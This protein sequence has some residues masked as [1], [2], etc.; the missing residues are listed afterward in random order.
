MLASIAKFVL[1]HK[2]LAKLN[3]TQRVLESLKPPAQGRVEY[4]DAFLTGFV[5]RVTSRGL[6]SFTFVYHCARAL[7]SRVGMEETFRPYIVRGE[8]VA[9]LEAFCP[10]FAGFFLYYP[11]RIHTPP[12]LR[13]LVDYMRTRTR[14]ASL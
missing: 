6:K 5:L 8:L 9:V 14:Q 13:A 11:S 4:S 2:R 12:K 1:G 3:L 10:S 7:A